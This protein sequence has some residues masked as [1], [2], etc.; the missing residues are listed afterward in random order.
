MHCVLLI[1]ELNL[2]MGHFARTSRLAEA[3]VDR[4]RV[5]LLVITDFPVP[6]VA[7]DC[8]DLRTL[9]SKEAKSRLDAWPIQSSLL[10]IA[11][12]IQPDA[13]FIEY[14]PF[15]RVSSKHIYM[16][17]LMQLH[18]LRTLRPLVFCSLRDIQDTMP[19]PDHNMYV[20]KLLNRWFDGLLIH[21]DP[22]FSRLEQSFELAEAIKIP[23]SYTNYVTRPFVPSAE[24]RPREKTIV[25]SSG[26]GLAAGRLLWHAIEAEK[27]GL[28]AGYTLRLFAGNLLPDREWKRLENACAGAE[29]S[30][31]L[32]RWTP[33]LRAELL[34]AAVSVSQ[35][36]Y[37]T[38]L[39]VLSSAVPAL[40]VPYSSAREPEQL[41]RARL[42]ADQGALR[43]L[44]REQLTPESLAAEIQE[45][46]RFTPRKLDVRMDG[47]ER[48]CD[49]VCDLLTNRHSA[50]AHIAS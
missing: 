31:Q 15:G 24:V 30:I 2:G 45:T 25:V 50:T 49:L 11:R 8:V 41:N 22:R 4:F 6:L 20:V 7:P 9:S 27:R 23:I 39:E 1:C 21:A 10:D 28:L 46:L 12:E 42:M 35:F 47:A 14:F 33:D 26:G 19:S 38:A 34:T 29:E 13:I 16:P 44:P 43:V 17:F 36:G 18:R 48:T 40:I 37:N 5:V 3:M 32:R